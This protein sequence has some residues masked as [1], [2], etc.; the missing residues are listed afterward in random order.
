MDFLHTIFTFFGSCIYKKNFFTGYEIS[1][2]S[3]CMYIVRMLKCCLQAAVWCARA[4]GTQLSETDLLRLCFFGLSNCKEFW[5]FCIDCNKKIRRFSLW[6]AAVDQKKS[7]QALPLTPL[8]MAPFSDV[9]YSSKTNFGLRRITPWISRCDLW[10]Q[11]RSSFSSTWNRI[12][13]KVD[14]EWENYG[15]GLRT[16]KESD[17]YSVVILHDTD[18][19][20]AAKNMDKKFY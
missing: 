5:K 20:R 1:I 8:A 7:V 16:V 18:T 3:L 13:T 10:L 9:K 4:T 19:K 11:L 6:W 2:F 14:L 15:P 17:L 12:L